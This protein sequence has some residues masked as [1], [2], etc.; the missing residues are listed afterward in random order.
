M[1]AILLDFN[2]TLFFDSGFH[3]KAWVEI[4]LRLNGRDSVVPDPKIYCGPRNDQILKS[5]GPWLTKEERDEWS[6]KKEQLYREMCANNPGK[7]S[8]SPGAV[9]LLDFIKESGLP[10]ALVSASIKDN[11]EF[12]FKQFGLSRWFSK[13]TVVY[14]DGSFLDKSEMYAEASRKLGV[15]LSECLCVE[16]SLTAIRHAKESKMGRIIGIGIETD[17]NLMFEAG[18]DH[19][20]RDFTEFD[21]KWI[22][23]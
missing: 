6:K 23:D 17:K 21:K 3:A 19:Y 16:D 12:Y 8:L 9:E 20:I 1:N 5:M 18:I 2:G 10:F 22:T 7:V 11:V 15:P 13:D 14:D 4:F